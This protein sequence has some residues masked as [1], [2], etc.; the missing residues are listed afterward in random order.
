MLREEGPTSSVTISDTA[1]DANVTLFGGSATLVRDAFLGPGLWIDTVQTTH[2]WDATL[3][4]VTTLALTTDD[5]NANTVDL[6]I[7][8]TTFNQVQ[9][10]QLVFGGTQNVQ[11][12]SV[13]TC[14]PNGPSWIGMITGGAQV[15]RYWW[16]RVNAV[17][18]T[19]TS[20]AGAN[21]HILVQRLDPNTLPPF[22]VPNPAVDDIYLANSTTWPVSAPSGSVVYRAFEET[23]TTSARVLN[24]FFLDTG[25]AVFAETTSQ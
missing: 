25:S 21:V 20:L 10:S 14:D 9:T 8:N 23:R 12:T 18:G 3:T 16:L 24:N 4:G 7:R 2:L 6:D 11:L 22:T 15:S 1:I 17:D 5:G 19:G 13:Q